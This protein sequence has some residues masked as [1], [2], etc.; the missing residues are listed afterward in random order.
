MI[1][2]LPFTLDEALSFLRNAF[3]AGS[4]VGLVAVMTR[5]GR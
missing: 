1:P 5:V 4:I 2:A 3:V